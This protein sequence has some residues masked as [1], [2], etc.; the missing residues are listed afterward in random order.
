MPHT[1]FQVC[2]LKINAIFCH[3]K[4][5][6]ITFEQECSIIITNNVY[7][8]IIGESVFKQT[9]EA[10]HLH[11]CLDQILMFLSI[12]NDAPI[13]TMLGFKFPSLVI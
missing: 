2:T 8:D 6:P 3:R 13:F 9:T 5:N 11:V 10:I 4:K 12:S 1:K 7:V